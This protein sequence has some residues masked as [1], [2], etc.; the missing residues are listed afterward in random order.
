MPVYADGG[1]IEDGGSAAEDV[2][3]HPSIAQCVAKQP[4][5]I[6]HLSFKKERNNHGRNNLDQIFIFC[7]KLFCNNYEI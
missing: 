3:R 2:E 5:R 4:F 7:N 6:V 1:Q